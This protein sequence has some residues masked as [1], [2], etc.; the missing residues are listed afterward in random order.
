MKKNVFVLALFFIV[1]MMANA[2]VAKYC[3]S[4][5]DFVAGNWKSVDELT[6]GRTQQVCQMKSGDHGVFYFKTGDKQSDEL[7]KKDAFAVMYGQQLFV[8]CRNLRYKDVSL[9]TSKYVQAVRYDKDKL[10]IM[11]YRTDGLT[12]LASVGTLV[13]GILVDDKALSLTLLG[14]SI[15][16]GIANNKLSDL[17]CF[18]VDSGANE[19]G[20][21][22]I[23]PHQRRL[24]GSTAGQRHPTIGKIQ[25]CQ[26]QAQ[27]PVGCQHPPH[28]DGEG[29]CR[30]GSK[31]NQEYQA[32]CK[33][34]AP[35]FRNLPFSI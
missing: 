5:D 15:G 27:P 4:Y 33:R 35:T 20:K 8:N 13:G 10:C 11:S 34:Q 28:S 14:T 25:G 1:S 16:C 26:G 12:A 29:T 7:L 9:E 24:Y 17:A 2:E 6:A 23:N 22:A 19:K 31:L 21:T 3:M 30:I 18:L 32:T